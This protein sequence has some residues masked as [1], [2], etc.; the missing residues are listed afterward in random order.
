MLAFSRPGTQW[1]AS[2]EPLVMTLSK[3][4]DADTERAVTETIEH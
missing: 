4:S 3:S 2:S 1:K